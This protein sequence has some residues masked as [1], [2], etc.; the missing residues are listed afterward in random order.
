M[1]KAAASIRRSASNRDNGSGSY[2]L[3]EHRKPLL[4]LAEEEDTE[5]R[6]FQH[7]RRRQGGDGGRGKEKK[8]PKETEDEWEM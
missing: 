6:G 4:D 1:A 7:G 8:S 3:G 2:A 5:D